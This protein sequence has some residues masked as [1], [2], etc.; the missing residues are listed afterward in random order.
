MIKNEKSTWEKCFDKKLF[1][2]Q[3]IHIDYFLLY[4]ITHAFSLLL[5]TENDKYNT[6]TTLKVRLQKML[7]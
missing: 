3:C 6:M 2:V 4:F 5:S 7:I 1:S